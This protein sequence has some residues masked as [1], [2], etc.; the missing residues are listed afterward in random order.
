MK[1]AGG[2]GSRGD[3]PGQ[4]QIEWSGA[5]KPVTVRATP[6]LPAPDAAPLVQRLRWDF[7]TTFPQPTPEALDAEIIPDEDIRPENIRAIHDEHARELL[8]VLRDLDAVLDARRRGVD[9]RNNKAPVL[10]PAKERL[11]KFFETEPVRLE[12][13]WQAQMGVYEEAFGPEAADA[14]GKAIRAWHA[15]IEV[16]TDSPAK[17]VTITPEP[18]PASKELFPCSS[19]RRERPRRIPARLPV[20]KPLP[21]A[22]ASGHFGQE[23]DGKPVRPGV[24]EVRAITEQQAEKLIEL[25][26]TIASAPASGKAALLES[27]Q[28]GLAA[29]AEDFGQPAADQL[30]AYARRQAGL[31]SGS[32]RSR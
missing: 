10:A 1:R 28:N 25:L 22:V 26:D 15:G 17:A 11:Q 31:D 4:L 9:P 3:V 32:R 20:P 16:A 24:S 8:A 2:H 23:E 7:K 14:F 5:A 18:K 13:W 19:S 6:S 30:E 12:R 21:A 29:Y 27:F